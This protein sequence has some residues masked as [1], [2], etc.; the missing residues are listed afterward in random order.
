MSRARW[1]LVLLLVVAAAGTTAFLRNRGPR[2]VEV[3][4]EKA[5]RRP[6]FRSYVTA[7]GEIVAARYAD[8]GSS[9]MGKL[10]QLLVKEG[11]VVRAGQVLAR[12]DAVPATSDEQAAGALLAAL[13]ADQ[14]A[15][16][17]REVEARQALERTRSL[18][19]Q[20]I[21]SQAEL[22]Q[23]IAAADSAHAAVEAATRRV[24]QG[25][26]QLSRVRDSLAKTEITAPMDGVVTRLSVRE[27]EMVVVGVQNQ[28]GTIL[29]T[30]SD[31]SSLDAEVKVAEVDVVR[32]AVGKSAEVTL[33]AL[34]GRKFTG[35]VTEIGA[36]SLP[37]TGATTA[38]REFRVVVRLTTPDPALK[39]GMTCDT[40]ILAEEV[41]D[42]TV[43]PLQAVT[44]RPA[45]EGG[46]R[47]GVFAVEADGRVRF[48]PVATGVIGGLDVTVGG[49]ADGTEIVAGP[50]QALRTLAD[51]AVVK[52]RGA[53]G[54]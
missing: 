38:A 2:P 14:A 35:H 1:G 51:G 3:D 39:P 53:P 19:R 23:A 29:M 17:A 24:A 16:A 37:P 6:I 43:V 15:A 40:A 9:T 8:I 45:P 7:S 41:A 49:L 25:R 20:G 52:R 12:L 30:L 18:V 28:P 13:G 34:P 33:E 4:V 5:V 44:L 48:V 32:L 10:V 22:D 27:G 42:A 50:F 46:E 31:L 36:S 54:R 21:Q 26:A 11:D 47:S